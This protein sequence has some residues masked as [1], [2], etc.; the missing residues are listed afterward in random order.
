M[1]IEFHDEEIDN[2]E[3]G[4]L[5]L[6]TGDSIDYAYQAETHVQLWCSD[7]TIKRSFV[8]TQNLV[9]AVFRRNADGTISY[10]ARHESYGGTWELPSAYEGITGIVTLRLGQDVDSADVDIEMI[11]EHF[12]NDVAMVV[13]LDDDGILCAWERQSE[14]MPLLVARSPRPL[15]KSTPVR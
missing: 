13:L 8:R 7:E 11:A 15:S 14:G 6:A 5:V 10:V 9:L 2:A 1:K 4:T 3:Q 12:M